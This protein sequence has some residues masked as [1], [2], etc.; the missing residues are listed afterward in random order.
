MGRYRHLGL[1]VRAARNINGY[2]VS[3]IVLSVEGWDTSHVVTKDRYSE[4][5]ASA[6]RRSRGRPALPVDRIVASAL[7]II[8][9][10]GAGALSMRGLAE[11]LDSGTATLYRH[12][13]DRS[14]LIAHVV[15]RVFGEVE[16]DGEDLSSMDW[17]DACRALAH[18]TF[19]ALSRHANVAPLLVEQVPMGPNAMRVRESCIAVL[20]ASGFPPSLAARSWA[21]LGRYVV[22][23]ATQINGHG[24][25]G[26][27]TDLQLS[28]IFHN[29]DRSLFP[30]TAAVADSLPV[31]LEDEFAFGLEL[32]LRGL[33]QL[34][35]S[36]PQPRKSGG[37]I[38]R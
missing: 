24:A 17:Q 37:R 28:S 38:E 27:L 34:G 7:E 12:F 4:E 31:P 8:D 1:G 11:R 30:A 32:I 35:D 5:E 26:H 14:D 3:V 6:E 25:S 16:L 2:N 21:T 23:F 29:L 9:E 18:T 13:T 22:G 19:K 10:A 33:R 20:L 36:D 15:D